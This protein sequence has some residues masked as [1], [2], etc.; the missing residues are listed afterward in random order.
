ME[1]ILIAACA[2]LFLCLGSGCASHS[3]F[4][5][6]LAAEAPAPLDGIASDAVRKLTTTWKPAKTR[7]AIQHPSA[8]AFGA[9][10]IG[11]LRTH[12]YSVMEFTPPGQARSAAP[13]AS[14]ASFA[15]DVSGDAVPVSYVL[16]RAGD[17]YRLKLL[18][19][20]DVLS[21]AYVVSAGQFAPAGAWSLL[22][23]E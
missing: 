20:R 3:P 23:Q 5:S 13:A 7:L 17:V 21:R 11:A 9:S 1:R 8:D 6:F 4:G 10:F 14:D 16:D 19:G 12:G 2:A 22:R 15:K 18:A